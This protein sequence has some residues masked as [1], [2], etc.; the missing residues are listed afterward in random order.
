MAGTQLRTTLMGARRLVDVAGSKGTLVKLLFNA[1]H[2]N[3]PRC[4]RQLHTSAYCMH[5]I[6]KAQQC[7]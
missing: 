6:L 3:A 1:H 7:R 2:L 5:T 4:R